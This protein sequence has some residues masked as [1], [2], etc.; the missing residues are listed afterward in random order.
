LSFGALAEGHYFYKDYQI[1]FMSIYAV[2]IIIYTIIILGEVKKSSLKLLIYSLPILIIT[3]GSLVFFSFEVVFKSLIP[4]TIYSIL[5]FIFGVMIISDFL[6]SPFKIKFRVLI[7]ELSVLIVIYLLI[8]YMFKTLAAKD[9]AVYYPEINFWKMRGYEVIIPITV[10]FLLI[11]SLLF[12][13][14][15]NYFNHKSKV[16]F[17]IFS[18]VLFFIICDAMVLINITKI[19]NKLFTL[20]I[21]ITNTLGQLLFCKAMIGKSYKVFISPK[22]VNYKTNNN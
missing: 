14:I 2:M 5:T 8:I 9:L 17:Y 6:K 10:I 12:F 4:I 20:L 13:T 22:K 11:T 15:V 21:F 3:F 1:I 18:G 7:I 19:E 16:N